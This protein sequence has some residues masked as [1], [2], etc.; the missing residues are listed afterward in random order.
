M[1]PY[2]GLETELHDVLVIFALLVGPTIYAMT[3]TLAT[4][5]V[6]S[7]RGRASSVF[8]RGFLITAIAHVVGTIIFVLW[9]LFNTRW[10]TGEFFVVF[11]YATYCALAAVGTADLLLAARRWWLDVDFHRRVR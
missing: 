3:V 11:I 10:S 1:L 5:Y 8:L 7:S 4:A 9:I 6:L 2:S